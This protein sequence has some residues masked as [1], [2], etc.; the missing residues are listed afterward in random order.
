M[1]KDT[2][3]Y[4]HMPKDKIDLKEFLIRVGDW[5]H[6]ILSRWMTILILGFL[7]GV[8]GLY[9]A[10]RKKPIYIATTTFVLENG[11]GASNNFGQYA[12][13]ASMVGLDLG[14]GGGGIFQG[15]NI[16]ELYK[17]R[18][19]IEK[20][21]FSQLD[22]NG[23]KKSLMECYLEINKINEDWKDNPV[24]LKLDFFNLPL[25][26]SDTLRS[27]N[28][29]RLRDSIVSMAVND[30]NANYL[31]IA[32][33][34]KKLNII[35]VDIKSK[36][37]QF[38][39]NF[40]N[41]IVRNVNDFYIQTKTKKALENVSILEEKTDSVKK[42]MNGVIYKAATV[43]D[44]TP[45]LNPTRQVLRIAPLQRAQFSA[46][47]N[48]AIFS[49]YSQNLEMAKMTLL[50]ETPLIQVIDQPVYP[51]EKK[52]TGKLFAFLVFGVLVGFLTLLTLVIS[53]ILNS[54]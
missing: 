28:T 2:V 12:G 5:C 41:S 16:I 44:A 46:E 21:L 18:T 42:V 51:L 35:K 34:D 49:T 15:E 13:I 8:I 3:D 39:K 37:E 17:S 6:Y 22:L 30:I 29:T 38:A 14:A 54:L 9:Y 10:T 24:L 50:K 45:N 11:E 23:R 7:G 32:K 33:Q 53:R 47:T 1:I 26:E 36:D 48:K 27:L 31:T 43:T 4:N 25:K 20:A 40:N 52:Q 19:M